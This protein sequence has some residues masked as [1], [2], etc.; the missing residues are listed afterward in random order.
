MCYQSLDWGKKMEH[1]LLIKIRKA[2]MISFSHVVSAQ[3]FP[4]QTRKAA[5]LCFEPLLQQNHPWNMMDHFCGGFFL[6]DLGQNSA[7]SI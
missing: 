3:T 5:P 2:I 6:L 4:G 1:T 7:I